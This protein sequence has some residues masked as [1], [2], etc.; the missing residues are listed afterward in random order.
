MGLPEEADGGTRTPD[1]IITSVSGDAPGHTRP[2]VHRHS[3]GCV[4]PVGPGAIP[5]GTPN[6]RQ[7]Q[8]AWSAGGTRDP[9]DTRAA[10][11]RTSQMR[12]VAGFEL[13]RAHPRTRSAGCPCAGIGACCVRAGA[14]R[15]QSV[16]RWRMMRQRWRMVRHEWRIP[17]R[18][19]PVEE[20]SP[21]PECSCRRW[22]VVSG[23]E[24]PGYKPAT[25]LLDDDRN[26]I[27]RGR[28]AASRSRMSRAMW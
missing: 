19:A 8:P 12:A 21:H 22:L 18:R 10:L 27:S 9:P 20:C 6:G 7:T 24:A 15:A 25:E 2:G 11:A 4:R 28:A 23:F 17:N 5:L 26:S 13:R 1:P 14:A 16:G 3:G